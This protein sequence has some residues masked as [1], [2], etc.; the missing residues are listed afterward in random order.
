VSVASPTL[1][2]SLALRLRIRRGLVL[3]PIGFGLA[4]VGVVLISYAW[5]VGARP[6]A[7]P[8]MLCLATTVVGIATSRRVGGLSVSVAGPR[9]R[10]TL[11]GELGIDVD[12]V[13]ARPQPA[14]LVELQVPAHPSL[15]AGVPALRAGERTTVR[16]RGRAA[17]RLVATSATVVV[18]DGGALGITSSSQTFA[19]ELDLAIVPAWHRVPAP[20]RSA[21]AVDDDGDEGFT[22]V[23]RPRWTGVEPRGP[24]PLR[25]GDPWRAVHARASA[26]R[27]RPMVREW[28]PPAAPR[29][30]VAVVLELAAAMDGLHVARCEAIVAEVASLAV[31]CDAAGDRVRVLGPARAA[32]GPAALGFASCDG[33]DDVLRRLAAVPYWPEPTWQRLMRAVSQAERGDLVLVGVGFVRALA[34]AE[35]AEVEQRVRA[36]GADVVLLDAAEVPRA[37]E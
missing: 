18:T 33:P 7:L 27:G 6:L 11:G 14:L 29:R 5:A 16:L 9:V 34:P 22:T 12:I 32:G 20:A 8:G 36:R 13:A 37:V 17:R 23:G 21:V 2:R 25:A 15:V 35:R 31:A 4:M 28:E 10:A 19:V 30:D 3:S 26:R 1:G 24:R